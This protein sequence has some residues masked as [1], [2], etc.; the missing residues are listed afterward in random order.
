[1]TALERGD[2]PR[3]VPLSP[4]RRGDRQR[5]LGRYVPQLDHDNQRGAGT[6]SLCDQSAS[7]GL[8]ASAQLGERHLASGRAVDDRWFVRKRGLANSLA[9]S[10]QGVGTLA[11][12]PISVYLIAQFGWRQSFLIYAA[13]VG[14]LIPV[15]MIWHRDSPEE[16][17][18]Q[19]DGDVVPAVMQAPATD[20]PAMTESYLSL[21]KTGPFWALF[22]FYLFR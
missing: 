6:K 14:I 17:G 20:V 2:Q 18:L 19:P 1:M 10:G 11:L 3:V 9:L 16:L 4:R 8:D 15:T 7:Q 22:F 13:L 21:M 5:L 12:A